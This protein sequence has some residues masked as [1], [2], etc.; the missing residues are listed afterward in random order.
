MTTEQK[1][2]QLE[3][4][5]AEWV[6]KYIDAG[7]QYI[8]LK[9]QLEELQLEKIRCSA[10]YTEL[11]K[12]IQNLRLQSD[13]PDMGSWWFYRP[14]LQEFVIE[15][16]E[17]RTDTSVIF[18]SYQLATHERPQRTTQSFHISSQE[19][20]NDSA[21]KYLSHFKEITEEEAKRLIEIGQRC[22]NTPL[23]EIK[24]LKG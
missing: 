18:K 11:E 23:G 17:T 6:G 16:V 3:K 13:L 10:K 5:H 12:A 22:D 2:K 1:I 19:E 9:K 4:R 7:K 14:R 8:E 24:Y 20:F 21:I 15:K